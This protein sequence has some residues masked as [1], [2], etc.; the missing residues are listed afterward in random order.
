MENS[1]ANQVILR[2]STNDFCVSPIYSPCFNIFFLNALDQL[3][4]TAFQKNQL[5]L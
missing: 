4:N 1:R 2:K 5:S 3:R